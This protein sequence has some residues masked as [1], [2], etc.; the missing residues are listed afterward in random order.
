MINNIL[1]EIEI[2]TGISKIKLPMDLGF[3]KVILNDEDMKDE[4]KEESSDFNNISI[5]TINYYGEEKMIPSN[6][7]SLI[8]SSK[9]FIL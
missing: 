5:S 6:F 7:I 9:D 2:E 3:M 4:L 8:Y 1:N